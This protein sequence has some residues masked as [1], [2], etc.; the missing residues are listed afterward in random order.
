MNENMLKVKRLKEET[1]VGLSTCK[2]YLVDAERDYDL[3]K[4]NLYVDGEIMKFRIN[5][6]KV[7]KDDPFW[8]IVS[9]MPEMTSEARKYWE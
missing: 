6:L 8:K 1:G 4:Q 7:N 9:R 5:A 2:Q 3:A